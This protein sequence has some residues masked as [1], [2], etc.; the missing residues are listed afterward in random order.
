MTN[1]HV[2]DNPIVTAEVAEPS[3][4]TLARARDILRERHRTR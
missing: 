4:A 3:L 2:A 1:W